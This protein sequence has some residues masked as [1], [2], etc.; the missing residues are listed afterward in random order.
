MVVAFGY[1]RGNILINIRLDTDPP[2]LRPTPLS[3]PH[4]H[5]ENELEV[6]NMKDHFA[7]PFSRAEMPR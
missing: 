5:Y 7:E 1:F 6:T 2:L 3:A 4:L